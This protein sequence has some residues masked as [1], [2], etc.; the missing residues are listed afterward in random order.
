MITLAQA[1]RRLRLDKR[2]T[3]REVGEKM[4]VKQIDYSLIERGERPEGILDALRAVNAMRGR[5]SRTEG[6]RF[7]TGHRIPR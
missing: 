4:G 5:T 2:L 7:R 1:L 3:Q 6:G